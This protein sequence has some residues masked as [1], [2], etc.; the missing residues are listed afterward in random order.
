LRRRAV[1]LRKTTIHLLLIRFSGLTF[2]FSLGLFGCSD[3]G[4]LERD[5]QDYQQRLAN[6]LEVP[7]P[8]L[9]S[10][11]SLTFPPSKELHITVPSPHIKLFELFQLNGCGVAAKIA[12]RNTQL[13]RTQYPSTRYVYEVELIASMQACLATDDKLQNK[14]NL[15]QWLTIKTQ[16]LPLVWADLIQNSEEIH[17]ALSA[18]KGF[19]RGNEQDGLRE[20][21]AA[22]QYLLNLYKFPQ[23]EP[24]LLEEHLKLLNNYQLPA[25]LWRSEMLITTAISQT[26]LWLKQNAILAM[27]TKGKP[28][29]QVEFLNNVFRIFFIEKIQMLSGRIDH[30]HYQLAPLLEQL[31]N[32]PEL[33]PKLTA[34]LS[35]Y[36]IDTHEQ[37]KLAL[38]EHIVLWQDLYRNCGLIP[39][40]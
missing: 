33:A 8:S 36:Q 11:P 15:V 5:L 39:G 4:S 2:I 9:I 23:A 7:G 18:N 38:Q 6:V 34:L 35:H 13:G 10:I 12:E 27:C 21:Q 26:T 3:R 24:H 28:S 1:L 32:Q 19:I 25:R 29:Q 17:H 31:I 22:L 14:Q 16:N 40:H 20:T 37:Y 30:Y